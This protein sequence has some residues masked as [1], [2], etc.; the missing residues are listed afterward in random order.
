MH[1]EAMK[2]EHIAGIHPPSYPVAFHQSLRP[3]FGY[4]KILCVMLNR[5]K[6]VRPLQNSQRANIDGAIVQ[7]DPDRIALRI[8]AHEPVI[9]M[10]MNCEVFTVGKNQSANWLGMNE[11]VVAHKQFH[12]GCQ[13]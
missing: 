11:Y 1:G 4:M 9:L 3:Y 8:A 12:D 13:S 10:R 7:W 5:P 6:T 2:H